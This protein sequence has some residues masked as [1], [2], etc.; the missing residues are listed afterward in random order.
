MSAP[1][2]AS[3]PLAD[4]VASALR[5][6]T[7]SDQ[8][9]ALIAE[10]DRARAAVEEGRGAAHA[11]ALDPT[12]GADAASAAKREAEDRRFEV[13]RLDSTLEALRSEHGEAGRVR[14]TRGGAPR[15]RPPG[16]SAT[17]WSIS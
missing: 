9:A 11:R 14:P 15:T 13:E 8:I 1:R 16:P 10:A 7:H 4:R 12:A 2:Q 17:P 6:R 5:E 3:L